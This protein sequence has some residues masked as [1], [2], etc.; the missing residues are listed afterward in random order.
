[1]RLFL[2]ELILLATAFLV[3]IFDLIKIG[4]KRKSLLIISL[5][6]ITLSF[7][8]LFV[9]YFSTV[10]LPMVLFSSFCVVDIFSIFFK[11]LFLVIGSLVLLMNFDFFASQVKKNEGEFYFL[12]ISSLLGLMITASSTNLLQIYLGL[13]LIGLTSYALAG[14]QK[15]VKRSAEASI[16]YFLF[17]AVSSAIFL[18]GVSLFYGL[19]G[20]I[21]LIHLFELSSAQPLTFLAII[22]MF[23]GFGFK[24]A[25]FPVQFWCPDVYE[26]APA[27][28]TTYLSVGPKA[29]GF[30]VLVRFASMLNMDF[31]QIFA[32]MSVFTMTWGN[33]VALKQK[34]VKRLMAYSSIA[35]AGYILIGL[36]SRELGYGAIAFYLLAYSF[37]NIGVFAVITYLSDAIGTETI[38]NYKGF[39]KRSPAIA[40]ALSILLL[41]LIGIPP[42]AG[43]IGKFLLFKAA[44]DAGFLWL[45]LVAVVNSVVSVFYYLGFVRAMYFEGAEDESQIKVSL[46]ISLVVL[47]CVGMTLLFGI[48]P[49]IANGFFLGI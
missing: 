7:V 20:S 24:I 15:T 39:A 9:P 40:A 28:V 41:S 37:A 35:Q 11:G 8:S 31:I 34:N 16:K 27:S 17:G 47:V 23:L 33:L 49:N 18:Y 10:T 22:F 19:T 21:N 25:M 12:L 32:I 38:D 43:F 14:F 30:A 13:E 44:I 26:G 45:A 5:A 46:L 42:L 6:G 3:L 1:M 36:V 2:P 4:P 29:A 48:L